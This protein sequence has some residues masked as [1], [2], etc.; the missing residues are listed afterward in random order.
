[1]FYSREKTIEKLSA[2][3]TP[4]TCNA[5][6]DYAEAKDDGEMNCYERLLINMAEFTEDAEGLQ[7]FIECLIKA[8]V[9]AGDRIDKMA[10]DMIYEW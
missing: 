5:L 8:D 10:G 2:W 1:M 9:A 7:Y 6:A 4:E 3:L